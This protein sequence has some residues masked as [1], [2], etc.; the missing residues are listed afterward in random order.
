MSIEWLDCLG[1]KGLIKGGLKTRHGY[2]LDLKHCICDIRKNPPVL[3]T[4]NHGY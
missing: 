3:N 4:K 2:S 1:C